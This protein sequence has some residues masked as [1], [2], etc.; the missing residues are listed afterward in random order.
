LIL[1]ALAYI[2]AVLLPQGKKILILRL[3]SFSFKP[4]KN[5]D[6]CLAL[7]IYLKTA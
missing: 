1:S 2:S 4:D 6:C 5:G 3:L 7:K